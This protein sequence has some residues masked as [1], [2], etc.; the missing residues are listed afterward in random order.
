MDKVKNAQPV[1]LTVGEVLF[2]L[3][4]I[5][6]MEQIDIRAAAAQSAHMTESQFSGELDALK[7]KLEVM[8]FPLA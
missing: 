8:T 3:S 7:D 5:R 2:V 4:M 6:A 1:T